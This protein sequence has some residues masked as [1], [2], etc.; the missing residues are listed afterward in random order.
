MTD[1]M[2]LREALLS[3]TLE[4]YKV[5]V[6]DEAHERTVSTDVLLG[7]LKQI[8]VGG[9]WVS[10]LG[11]ELFIFFFFSFYPFFLSYVGW[12]VAPMLVVVDFAY[13][14]QYHLCPYIIIVV[15]FLPCMIFLFP[16]IPF[17]LFP[18]TFLPHTCPHHTHSFHTHV[19]TTHISF[20]HHLPSHFTGITQGHPEIAYHVGDIGCGKVSQLLS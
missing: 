9:G 17:T 4:R 16:H 12:V 7:L 5:V 18:H 10:G 13:H 15:F 20:T 1:G 6:V 14:S 3:P 8:Q 11:R 2:L 19:L